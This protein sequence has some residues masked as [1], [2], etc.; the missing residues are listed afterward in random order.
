M[1]LKNYGVT[2]QV[3]QEALTPVGAAIEVAKGYFQDRIAHGHPG[4][5][6]IFYIEAPDGEKTTVALDS[7]MSQLDPVQLRQ[8]FETEHPVHTLDN[9]RAEVQFQ[10]TILGYW[11]WVQHK[12]EQ[13]SHEA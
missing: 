10:D 9:W 7:V 1:E 3:D 2:W 13:A 6:C 11:E 4:T 5:A 8:V 12:L